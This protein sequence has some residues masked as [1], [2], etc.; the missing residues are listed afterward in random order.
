MNDGTLTPLAHDV[1]A[2]FPGPGGT[3]RLVRNHE[4]RNTPSTVTPS[5]REENR[6]H[7]LG[8][9]G[10]STL[11]VRITP[12]GERVLDRALM[13]LSGTIV[14]CAGGPT[15]WGSWLTCE[16]TTAGT[17]AGWERDHGY[18]FEAPAQRATRLLRRCLCGRWVGSCMRL[19]P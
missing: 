15:P 6:Y 5:G 3:V 1:M 9:G 11:Q 7:V 8:G 2:A 18:V 4:E 17:A 14:N 13:S 19:P 12:S 10:T 16:E